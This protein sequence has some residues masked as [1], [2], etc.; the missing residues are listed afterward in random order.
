MSAITKQE[1]NFP[2]CLNCGSDL[3][4]WDR[5]EEPNQ[6]WRCFECGSI[7]FKST[8]SDNLRSENDELA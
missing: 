2:I 1:F 5:T 8:K 7:K 6:V 4:D 3:G